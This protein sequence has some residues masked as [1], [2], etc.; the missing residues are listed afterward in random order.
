VS[1]CFIA[2][3]Q[4]AMKRIQLTTGLRR[5]INVQAHR[6]AAAHEL[7]EKARLVAIAE[8]LIMAGIDQVTI[9]RQIEADSLAQLACALA[10]GHG[11]DADAA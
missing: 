6:S 11:D 3:S 10:Q 8:K 2:N 9:R 1:N 4:L 7:A 5:Q